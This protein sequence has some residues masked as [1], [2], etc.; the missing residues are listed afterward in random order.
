M[1][2]RAHEGFGNRRTGSC[3]RLAAAI[4]HKNRIIGIGLNQKKTS[5]FQAKFGKN[6]NS[7][8]VHAEIAAIKQALYYYDVEE[9]MRLKTTLYICRVKKPSSMPKG[10]FIW[11]ISKPCHGCQGAIVEFRI[12]K[13]IYTL[14]EDKEGCKAYE[15]M[16]FA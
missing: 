3:A 7:I 10:P 14:D 4:Y 8:F 5:P 15:I 13:I 16:E 2:A 6:E 11:G 9:L 12:N 1:I